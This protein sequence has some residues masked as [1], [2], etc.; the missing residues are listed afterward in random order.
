[1]SIKYLFH[2]F[3]KQIFGNSLID[4]SI[5]QLFLLETKSSSGTKLT[6]KLLHPEATKNDERYVTCN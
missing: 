1:M 6:Q 2:L 4:H 5:Q 3:Q